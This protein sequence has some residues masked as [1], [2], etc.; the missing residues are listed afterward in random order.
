M[1]LAFV[2]GEFVPLPEARVSPLDRAYMYGDG[3]FVE[4]P[5]YGGTV[6]GL[7]AHLRRLKAGLEAARIANLLSDEQ[8]AKIFNRIIAFNGGPEQI[9]YAQVSRGISGRGIVGF[10]DQIR[11]CVF[12]MGRV[13][14]EREEPSGINAI[15]HQDVRPVLGALSCVSTFANS[16]LQ[17]TAKDQGADEAILIH[18]GQVTDGASSAVFVVGEDFVVTPP[19]S[20]RLVG[21][22]MRDFVLALGNEN[23]LPMLEAQVSLD[24]LN[25]AREVFVVSPWLELT[26]VLSIDGKPVGGG[27]P[28]PVWRKLWRVFNESREQAQLVTELLAPPDPAFLDDTPQ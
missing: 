26:P 17:Q 4:V 23:N 19:P 16:W 3:V 12:A 11:P 21:G 13:I 14:L 27:N 25:E 9:L 22:V 10:P 6:F 24:A 7:D 5:V 28:G 2:N 15:T 1:G 18:D 20:D 8:W